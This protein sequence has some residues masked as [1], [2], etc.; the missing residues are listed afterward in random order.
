MYEHGEIAE[1]LLAHQLKSRTASQHIRQIR[2]SSS[3]VIND[4]FK[5]YYTKLYTA[6]T[7]STDTCRI[8]C[9]DHLEFLFIP[10]DK[11]NY[12]DQPLTINKIT[13]AIKLMQSNK[14]PGPDGYPIEFH[15]KS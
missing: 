5:N 15:K 6:E 13:D 7:S 9:L 11:A 3:S 1:Q 12:R 4:T 14:V 2:T 10:P 8:T